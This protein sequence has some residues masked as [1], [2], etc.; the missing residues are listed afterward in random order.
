MLIKLLKEIT[1]L[2]NWGLYFN[3]ASLRFFSCDY[4][5][6]GKRWSWVLVD[7]WG[8]SILSSFSTGIAGCSERSLASTSPQFICGNFRWALTIFVGIVARNTKRFKFAVYPF[9]TRH[10]FVLLRSKVMCTS[11]RHTCH[12]ASLLLFNWSDAPR[13]QSYLTDVLVELI[14][15][16]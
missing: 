9:S 1:G 15:L 7:S 3:H 2:A 5:S 11:I 6:Y 12:E 13:P 14:I 10:D 4:R 16:L 8:S